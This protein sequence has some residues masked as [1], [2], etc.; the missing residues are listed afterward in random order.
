MLL[1]LLVTEDPCF[2]ERQKESCLNQVLLHLV[3]SSTGQP[4]TIAAAHLLLHLP[5]PV[6]HLCHPLFECAEL[7]QVLIR[8][9]YRPAVLHVFQQNN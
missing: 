4:T 9:C 7:L 5:H 1:L 8:C 6:G 3:A 2:A